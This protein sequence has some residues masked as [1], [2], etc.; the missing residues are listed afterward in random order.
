[1]DDILVALVIEAA[2]DVFQRVG[3]VNMEPVDTDG[4]VAVDGLE[5]STIINFVGSITGAYALRCSRKLAGQIASA[6]LGTTIDEDS[7]ATLDALGELFNMIVGVAKTAHNRA[8][9]SYKM[10]VP[11]TIVG[12]NFS[13]HIQMKEGADVTTLVFSNGTET[14]LLEIFIN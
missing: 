12:G 1:M 2:T 4:P 7:E 14:A 10:T 3:G 13:I 5:V 11:T 6:M 9:Q 8:G